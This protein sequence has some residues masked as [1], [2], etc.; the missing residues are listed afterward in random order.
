MSRALIKTAAAAAI[1]LGALAC[2]ENTSAP[3]AT[4]TSSVQPSKTLLSQPKQVT[5]LQRKTPLANPVTASRV[6]G[7]L[8]GIIALP[9]AGL[10]IVVPP[11][12]V[13]SPTTISV[14]AL[15]G[16][17]V[18]YEFSPHGTHFLL[19]LIA[20]QNLLITKTSGFNLLSFFAGYYQSPADLGNGTATITEA[21]SLN[22]EL[23]N[24]IAVFDISHFS[25]YL[26]ATGCDES[27]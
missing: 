26:V 3:P 22:I 6:I 20:T 16:S 17:N 19:P 14:T 5:V 7:I 9:S 21:L 4:P 1:A 18:A 24:T 10:T 2:G 23:L 12:A 11:G 13:L 25:G 15:A 8:G 27:Q